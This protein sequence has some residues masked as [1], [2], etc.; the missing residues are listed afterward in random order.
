[1]DA[2]DGCAGEDQV[3][4][5]FAEGDGYQALAGEG[6]LLECVHSEILVR[7][8]GCISPHLLNTFRL[9]ACSEL[10]N[11]MYIVVCHGVYLAL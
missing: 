9:T 2:E 4:F 1:M 7:L 5:R 8:H 3:G 10:R 11:G 6:F